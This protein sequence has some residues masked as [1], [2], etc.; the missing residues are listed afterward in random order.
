LVSSKSKI[1]LTILFVLLLLYSKKVGIVSKNHSASHIP[2][3]TPPSKF[4]IIK[5]Y[6]SIYAF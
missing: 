1:A 3:L 2:Q 5:F 4:Y 6:N